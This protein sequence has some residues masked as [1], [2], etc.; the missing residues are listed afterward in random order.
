MYRSVGKYFLKCFKSNTLNYVRREV[1]LPALLPSKSNCVLTNSLIPSPFILSPCNSV[2]NGPVPGSITYPVYLLP[3]KFFLTISYL[4]VPVN[5]VL[6]FSC[7]HT[8]TKPQMILIIYQINNWMGGDNL[9]IPTTIRK[10]GFVFGNTKVIL[11]NKIN[12]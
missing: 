7:F 11:H 12:G 8:W 1:P 2:F 3:A 6:L 10:I 4:W 9:S 5:W